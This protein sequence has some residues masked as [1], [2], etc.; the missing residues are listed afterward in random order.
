MLQCY[1]QQRETGRLL[2]IFESASFRVDL[3]HNTDG[4]AWEYR[5]NGQSET[6]DKRRCS[7]WCRHAP[8]FAGFPYGKL[9]VKEMSVLSSLAGAPFVKGKRQKSLTTRTSGEFAI[10]ANIILVRQSNKALLQ[11]FRST[12]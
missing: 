12:S 5:K 11:A 9:L 2:R 1:Q 10:A 7:L 8:E 3:L 4:L 6:R